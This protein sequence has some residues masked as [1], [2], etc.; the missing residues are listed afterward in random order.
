MICNVTL[1]IWRPAQLAPLICVQ[2]MEALRHETLQRLEDL[3][4]RLR[5]VSKAPRRIP[6]CATTPRSKRQAA[7]DRLT[8]SRPAQSHRREASLL[9]AAAELLGAE[10]GLQLREM[11]EVSVNKMMGMSSL[12]AGAASPPRAQCYYHSFDFSHMSCQGATVL[13]DDVMSTIQESLSKNLSGMATRWA[14]W[15]IEQKTTVLDNYD[16]CRRELLSSRKRRQPNGDE[17]NVIS[18]APQAG[19]PPV[20]ISGTADGQPEPK[21]VLLPPPSSSAET[22]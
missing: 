13:T 14:E 3:N 4:T 5:K 1:T 16:A 9:T 8:S 21:R 6:A 20:Q 10:G 12:P 19:Q 17:A 18:A 7:S 15:L 22:S 11:L 2:E